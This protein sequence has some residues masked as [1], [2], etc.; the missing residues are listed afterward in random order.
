MPYRIEFSPDSLE[1]LRTLTARQQTIVLATI[2]EQLVYEPNV[3][4]RNRKLMR[5]NRF[6]TWELRIDTL[7]VYYDVDEEDEPL[8]SIR[9]IGIKERSQILIMG[10]VIDFDETY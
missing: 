7:R 4:T 6:A 2:T 1:H 5:P 10:E 3:P 8:V 9:A